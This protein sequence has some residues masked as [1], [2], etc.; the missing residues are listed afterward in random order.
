MTYSCAYFEGPD[1]TLADAQAAKH[2]LV[3]RKLGLPGCA[4]AGLESP[5]CW[6]WAAAGAPW[7][8]HAAAHHGAEAVGITISQ[9]QAERARARVG[10]P[11]WRTAW[12]SGCRTTATCGGEQ[13]DAISSI[14]MFEHVG[15]ERM[16]DY[17]DDPPRPAPARGAAPQP[18]H[19]ERRRLAARAPELHRP[20]RLPRRRAAR[21]Q[22]HGRRDGGGRVRGPGRRT[23]SGSTTPARCGAGWPTWRPTGTGPSR[24]SARHGPGSGASTWPGSAVGFDDGGVSIHQV[25]GVVPAPAAPAGCPACAAPDPRWDAGP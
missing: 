3:C 4:A 11:G 16:A 25:L 22:R 9:E 6:T 8:S 24:S 21:R 15:R 14:G 19:L 10:R 12:R 13:F 2:D 7:R 17:F 18:R 23:R 1:A 20:V 5:R